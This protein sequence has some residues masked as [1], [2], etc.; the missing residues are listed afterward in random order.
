LDLGSWNLVLD[1][2]GSCIM[3]KT[4]PLPTWVYKRDGRMVP[5]EAD[6]ISQSLFAA[7][8]SLDR[9]DVFTARELTD[10]VLHFL[11]VELR[12]SIPST[13]Q[14]AELVV[15]VVR[16]LGQSTIAQEYADFAGR[17]GRLQ[18]D[19]GVSKVVD[20]ASRHRA[21]IQVDLPSPEILSQH[22]PRSLMCKVAGTRLQEYSLKEIF[23][24]DIAAAHKEG[25]IT[26]AGL[27]TPFEIQGSVLAPAEIGQLV[28]TIEEFR[29]SVGQF[30][31]LDGLEFFDQAHSAMSSDE[32]FREFQIGLRATGL[33]ALVNLNCATPPSWAQNLATGPLFDD[34]K[35]PSTYELKESPADRLLDQILSWK[36]QQARVHWHLG[37]DDFLAKN[38][39]RINRLAHLIGQGSPVTVVFDRLGRPVSLAEG[40]DRQH[41]A[42]LTT[43]GVHLPRLAQQAGVAASPD[44]FLQKLRSL[45]RLALT[46]AV[47]K[48]RFL[49]RYR[50]HRPAF[51]VDRARLAVVPV[52]LEEV[53]R[54]FTG[55]GVLPG[56]PGADF[57]GRI[58]QSLHEILKQ[59]GPIHNLNACLDSAPTIDP[60]FDRS[61]IMPGIGQ[62]GPTPDPPLDS[63]AGLTAWNEAISLREQIQAASLLQASVQAGTAWIL[64]PKDGS[65]NTEELSSVLRFAWKETGV[66]RLRFV[67]DLHYRSSS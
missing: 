57:A 46:G 19:E 45:A 1:W 29:L 21:R 42:L 35:T 23:T 17:K 39:R 11:V 16:E 3:E 2:D 12:D 7:T 24:R 34:S 54:S 63:I 62:A 58:V 65:G 30:V 41:S 18:K 56:S 31:S 49:V 43:V 26:L 28:E 36:S 20:D 64:L 53:A 66:S 33:Q 32:W 4:S 14:I 59:E 37:E 25:L 52:G 10:G 13:T 22:D 8:E 5:F 6:K 44:R 15:K 60:V 38:G 51:L 55:Q 27:D 50:R 9:P 47:Q 48:R 67:S 61:S 40:M